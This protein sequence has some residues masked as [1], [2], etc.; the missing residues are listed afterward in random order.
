MHRLTRAAV[1]AA[2]LVAVL[3]VPSAAHAAAIAVP[4]CARVLPGQQTIPISGTGFTGG[5]FVRVN[6]AAGANNTLG[7]TNADAAGN[8][9]GLFFGP[10]FPNADTNQLTV[11]VSAV[12]DRG[13][14]SAPVPLQV[15]RITATLPDRARPTSRVRYRVFGFE[16]GRRVYLHIRRGGKTRGSFRISKA[17]GPCG[18]ASRRLRYMPLRRWSTGIYDYYFQHTRRFDRTKP[19]V[20][21]RISIVRRVV[22]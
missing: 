6:D 20:K 14:A 15:V 19:G 5:S 1:A 22:G 16:S 13:V 18:I 7:S 4:P 9:N 3:A 8:F 11:N 12:D 2:G 21:L 10:T 17:N